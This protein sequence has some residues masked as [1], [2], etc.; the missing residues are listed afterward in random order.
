LRKNGAG[1]V[2]ERQKKGKRYP[3]KAIQKKN[4]QPRKGDG[5][6][7]PLRLGMVKEGDEK[8]GMHGDVWKGTVGQNAEPLLRKSRLPSARRTA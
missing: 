8:K 3:K 7:R 5:T 4:K 6:P 1:V 2:R